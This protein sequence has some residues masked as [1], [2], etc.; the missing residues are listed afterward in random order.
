MLYFSQTQASIYVTI[1]HRHA[2]LDVDGVKSTDEEPNVVTEHLFLIFHDL[3][4]NQHSLHE[5]QSL[6]ARH[7]KGINY[8]V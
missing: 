5:V 3:K 7:L 2:L 1:L 8:P 6:V 4:H